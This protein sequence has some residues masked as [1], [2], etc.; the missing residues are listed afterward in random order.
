MDNSL[1][2]HMK[3]Y[4]IC[5]SFK[6]YHLSFTFL[7]LFQLSLFFSIKLLVDLLLAAKFLL[8]LASKNVQEIVLNLVIAFLYLEYCLFF[9]FL[10]L[11]EGEFFVDIY[12]GIRLFLYFFITIK[13]KL[14]I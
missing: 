2:N 8:K 14:L 11:S 9:K 7:S 5:L 6:K 12:F 4:S 10:N 1:S 13:L 3:H